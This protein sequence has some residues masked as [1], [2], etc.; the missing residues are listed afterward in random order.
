MG[1]DALNVG[2]AL[3]SNH[4]NDILVDIPQLYNLLFNND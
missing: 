1:W 3:N 2:G 4:D